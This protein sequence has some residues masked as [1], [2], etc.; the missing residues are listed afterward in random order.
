MLFRIILL[1]LSFI[2]ILLFFTEFLIP[3][4]EYCLYKEWKKKENFEKHMQEL[5]N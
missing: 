4:L 2:V 3:E 1:G 5:E